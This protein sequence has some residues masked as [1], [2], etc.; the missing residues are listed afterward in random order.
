MKRS[1]NRYKDIWNKAKKPVTEFPVINIDEEF[2]LIR[3][4][5]TFT[6]VK[7]PAPRIIYRIARFAAAAIILLAVSLSIFTGV[8]LLEYKTLKASKSVAYFVL[9]DG[10]AVALY[11]GTSLRYRKGL[12]GETRDITLSGE[13]YFEVK[14][15]TLG[16]SSLKQKI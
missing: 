14:R 8:R 9:P 10:S 15:D 16:P 6:S 12:K 5:I 13:T 1:Y 4:K 11:P 7:K 2:E 3:Q